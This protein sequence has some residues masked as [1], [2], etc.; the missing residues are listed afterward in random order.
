[1][2][3][4][5]S[6]A[7]GRPAAALESLR[8]AVQGWEDAGVRDHPA[9]VR[10]LAAQSAAELA[11]GALRES[12]SSMQSALSAVSRAVA[13]THPLK[14]EVSLSAA[15]Q[16]L[17]AGDARGALKIAESVLGGSADALTLTRAA[18]VAAGAAA[19]LVGWFPGT[20]P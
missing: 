19:S 18:A 1:M 15:V 7:N 2:D 5:L 12:D 17:N 8:S 16:A 9:L 14:V 6:L 10:A 20:S 11:V 13:D 3:G 4:A